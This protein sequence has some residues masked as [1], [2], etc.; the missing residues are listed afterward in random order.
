MLVAFF[1][2]LSLIGLTCVAA[3]IIGLL[4]KNMKFH[5]IVITAFI[6]SVM[7]ICFALISFSNK[8]KTCIRNPIILKP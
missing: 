4:N 8:Q 5:K 2:I 7:G 1:W 3:F 6:I